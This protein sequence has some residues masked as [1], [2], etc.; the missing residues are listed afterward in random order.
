MSKSILIFTFLISLFIQD[1]SHPKI[2]ILFNGNLEPLNGHVKQIIEVNHNHTI[3]ASYPLI[4]TTIANFD[5]NGNT[6]SERNKDFGDKKWSE[7]KYLNKYDTKGKKTETIIKSVKNG[8]KIYLYGK[9][10]NIDESSS[11]YK[12]KLIEKTTYKYDNMD[13]LVELTSNGSDEHYKFKYKYN[14][15]QNLIEEDEFYRNDPKG[16]KTFDEYKSFDEKGNWLK[17][18]SVEHV[19][20]A[21]SKGSPY[22]PVDTITRK[23]TYYR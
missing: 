10:G 8:T 2:P 9:D 19:N 16:I 11:W 20:R 22:Y 12:N 3:E 7:I 17:K 18:I 23:I 21:P 1:G 15:Q 5:K 6:I 4:I 13:N 14:N